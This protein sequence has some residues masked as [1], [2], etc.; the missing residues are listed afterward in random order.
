MY[1]IISITRKKAAHSGYFTNIYGEVCSRESVVNQFD[2]LMFGSNGIEKNL[3][4]WSYKFRAAFNSQ[5]PPCLSYLL[6]ILEPY[7]KNAGLKASKELIRIET[8]LSVIDS[9]EQLHTDYTTHVSS[10]T[11]MDLYISNLKKITDNM[12]LAGMTQ[13]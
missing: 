5:T 1:N 7:N 12:N 6:N 2:E 11:D 8:I 4:T 3:K 9:L 10:V 13:I